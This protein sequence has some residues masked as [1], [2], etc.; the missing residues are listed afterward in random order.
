ML[1]EQIQ[2]L[3]PTFLAAFIGWIWVR[4]GRGFD[5]E[6]LG[7]LITQIEAPCLIFSSIVSLEVSSDAMLQMAL[8]AGA[9]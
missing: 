5:R 6:M 7:D 8:A 3:A 2:I 4:S 1:C 9:A